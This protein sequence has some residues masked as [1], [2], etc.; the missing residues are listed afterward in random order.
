MRIRHFRTHSLTNT[1]QFKNLLFKKFEAVRLQ[2]EKRV[3]LYDG[4]SLKFRRHID[5]SV[6]RRHVMS[7]MPKKCEQLE[8]IR[9]IINLSDHS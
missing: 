4:Y 9:W 5:E 8:I 7:K 2:V 3:D 6:E 1:S